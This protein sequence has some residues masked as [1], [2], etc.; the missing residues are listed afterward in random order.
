[1]WRKYRTVAFAILTAKFKSKKLIYDDNIAKSSI[2]TALHRKKI[3]DLIW[4]VSEMN[5]KRTFK[6][7]MKWIYEFCV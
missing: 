3:N 1:M 6:W 7:K 4:I 5:I 2:H